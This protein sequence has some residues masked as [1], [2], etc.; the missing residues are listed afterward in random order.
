M[1][2]AELYPTSTAALPD[3]TLSIYCVTR[4][5][6]PTLW[7]TQRTSVNDPKSPPPCCLL[8]FLTSRVWFVNKTRSSDDQRAPYPAE[9]PAWTLHL[10]CDIS[11]YV[12]THERELSQLCYLRLLSTLISAARQ[13]EV[14]PNYIYIYIYPLYKYIYIYIYRKIYIYVYVHNT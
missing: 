8:C 2:S 13:V 7:K 10:D 11:S 12:A 5:L 1:C 6:T 4:K 9:C 14:L 3:N